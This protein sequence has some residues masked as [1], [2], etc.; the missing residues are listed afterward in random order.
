MTKKEP[1]PFW[2]YVDID[3]T[4][5]YLRQQIHSQQH[6]IERLNKEIVLLKIL[7]SNKHYKDD[8]EGQH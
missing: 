3:D 4:E 1:I 5:E 7:A 8:P 2:G 6:E